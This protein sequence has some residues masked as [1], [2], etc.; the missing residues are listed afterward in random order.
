MCFSSASKGQENLAGQE[1][2]LS[3]ILSQ[4]F[5]QNFG[6]Q[7]TVLQNLQNMYTPI[8]EAGPTQQGYGAAEQAALNTQA[9]QGVGTNY[10]NASRALNAQIAAQGGGNVALPSGA[11]T[12]NKEQL[13]AAAAG[14]TSQLQNQN[15]VNNYAQGNANWQVANAG[16]SGVAQQ[17]NP[18]SY[19]GLASNTNQAAFG[20]ASQLFQQ[21]Q[22]QQQQIAGLATSAAL[23]VGTF[24]AGAALGLGPA[25]A[26]PFQSG[27]TGL[28][29][30]QQAFANG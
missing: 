25:G 6:Q 14:T 19:A 21:Q 20:Q 29:G 5:A 17:Y 23:D 13:A 15:I 18:Q 27:L 16:L 22:Q 26:S 30:G 2:Q 7:S 24:G 10:G 4:E 28:F 12:A 11:A 3:S 8:S 1:S 9:V